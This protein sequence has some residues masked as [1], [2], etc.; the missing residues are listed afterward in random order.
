MSSKTTTK[1][2]EK[3][4]LELE[5]EIEKANG[6]DIALVSCYCV[7]SNGL[8][9]PNATPYV[10]FTT[11]RLGKIVGTGSDVCDHH[12]VTDT[13]RK[14]RAGRSWLLISVRKVQSS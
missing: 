10:S 13:D 14:M 12:P 3:L 11:N 4:V 2:P 8:E 1:R 5:N 9:V 7:D 6:R